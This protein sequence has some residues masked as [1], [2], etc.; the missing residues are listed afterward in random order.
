MSEQKLREAL[1][2]AHRELHEMMLAQACNAV[3]RSPSLTRE[4]NK[5]VEEALASTPVQQ[6]VSR[7]LSGTW[8]ERQVTGE[9]VPSRPRKATRSV[10][11]GSA[12][13]KLEEIVKAMPHRTVEGGRLTEQQVSFGHYDHKP[14]HCD[15]CKLTAYALRE[16]E[17]RAGLVARVTFYRQFI[18]DC[19]S[20]EAEPDTEH[21]HGWFHG[22]RMLAEDFVKDLAALLEG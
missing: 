6:N 19:K 10:E 4:A 15:L 3:P 7:E 18:E 11:Q 5:A 20:G 14:E 21:E 22:R 12:G 17:R 9:R 1:R 8:D 16:R 13:M 2:L